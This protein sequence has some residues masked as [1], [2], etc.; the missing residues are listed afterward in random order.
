MGGGAFPVWERPEM[1]PRQAYLQECK[2]NFISPRLRS[3]HFREEDHMNRVCGV[4]T[5]VLLSLC[6]MSAAAPGRHGDDAAD[7]TAPSYDMKAQA[8]LDL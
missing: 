6:A 8:L 5:F 2:T 7:H 1:D 4:L 3:D